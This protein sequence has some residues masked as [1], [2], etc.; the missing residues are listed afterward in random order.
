VGDGTNK[1]KL[2][3]TAALHSVLDR[4]LLM[5][6][7]DGAHWPKA[8]FTAAGIAALRLMARDR[9]ALPPEGVPDGK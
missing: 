2:K 8:N 3:P 4:G 6:V 1:G 5:L 9:R 7:D